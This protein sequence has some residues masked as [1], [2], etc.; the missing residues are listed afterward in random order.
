MGIDD[1]HITP[2]LRSVHFLKVNE[3]FEYE[4][5]SLTYKILTTNQPT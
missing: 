3:R 1:T 5:R 2:I 4:L